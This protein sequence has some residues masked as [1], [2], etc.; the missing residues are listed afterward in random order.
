[1]YEDV[2][3][4]DKWETSSGA[5]GCCGSFL[6]VHGLIWERSCFG[7][8]ATS[9]QVAYKLGI[10]AAGYPSGSRS[11]PR[12]I[13]LIFRNIRPEYNINSSSGSTI[14]AAAIQQQRTSHRLI[15]TREERLCPVFPLSTTPP[16][17][18]S[19]ASRI[20]K[21]KHHVFCMYVRVYWYIPVLYDMVS[22]RYE[23]GSSESGQ[24]VVPAFR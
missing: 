22:S 23:M 12:T 8:A 10:T 18:K 6:K 3:E 15:Y 5:I 11:S 21:G 1:M 13:A 9:N 2:F 20:P 24:H 4:D 16:D 17:C 7:L 14:A 19:T